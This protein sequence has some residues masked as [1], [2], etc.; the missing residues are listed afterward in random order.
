MEL[1]HFS[2][3]SSRYPGGTLP[4]IENAIRQYE[5]QTGGTL[6]EERRICLSGE[7]W[8]LTMLHRWELCLGMTAYPLFVEGAC[9]IE[10]GLGK[11]GHFASVSGY[12]L[13][14]HVRPFPPCVWLCFPCI[15]QESLIPKRCY[16]DFIVDANYLIISKCKQAK[17]SN[18]MSWRRFHS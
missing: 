10:Q 3:G 8:S 14:F 7:I 16:S 5:T 15:E 4:A 6:E 18:V 2:G 17:I 11:N 13:R 9:L 1:Q 12:N